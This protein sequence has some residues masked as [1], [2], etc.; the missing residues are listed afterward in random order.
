MKIEFRF[1]GTSQIIL[2]PENQR[3]KDLLSMALNGRPELRI[4]PTAGEERIIEAVE[5]QPAALLSQSAASAALD[6]A[7]G[8]DASEELYDPDNF[9]D[10]GGRGAEPI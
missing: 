7:A 8:R 6:G 9:R 4:K 3:D 10:Q 2:F 5:S 1:N